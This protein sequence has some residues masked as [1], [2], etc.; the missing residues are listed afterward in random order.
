VLVP[1]HVNPKKCNFW[2]IY[3][4][5]CSKY[6][7]NRAISGVLRQVRL[8]QKQSGSTRV[9]LLSKTK[10]LN[11]RDVFVSATQPNGCGRDSAEEASAVVD[12]FQVTACYDNLASN[13]HVIPLVANQNQIKDMLYTVK[14]NQDLITG[15]FMDINSSATEILRGVDEEA[16]D[17]IGKFNSEEAGIISKTT[18]EILLTIPYLDVV[19]RVGKSI[20]SNGVVN[21]DFFIGMATLS[22]DEND[23]MS[24][25]I[26]TRDV[27]TQI[28]AS[29]ELSNDVK[30]EASAIP[31]ISIFLYKIRSPDLQKSWM[32]ITY[33][34]ELPPTSEKNVVV[35]DK[36][37][38]IPAD[39]VFGSSSFF[40][41]KI[42]TVDVPTGSTIHAY[43]CILR[44]DMQS[45]SNF[46]ADTRCSDLQSVS[47]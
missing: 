44:P 16:E 42:H 28:G 13:Y 21:I 45:F 39:S 41:Q 37:D 12:S 18:Y 31:S 17:G 30:G 43:P 14:N 2:T 26:Q 4:H 9:L 27:F 46:D 23:R 35:F 19:E 8:E 7:I 32:F 11:E 29:Y 6:D 3:E 36:E 33:Q 10:V 15:Q 20:H 22:I 1:S 25:S 5:K 34:I 47:L 38:V 24:T 40:Q